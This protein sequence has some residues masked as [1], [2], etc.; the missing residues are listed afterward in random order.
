[1]PHGFMAE[2][3]SLLT[4]R[5]IEHISSASQWWAVPYTELAAKTSVVRVFEVYGCFHLWALNTGMI[6]GIR[7]FNIRYS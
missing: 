5:M 2:L 6:W 4:Y 1:M 3:P 7:W